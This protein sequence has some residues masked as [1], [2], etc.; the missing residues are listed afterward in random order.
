MQGGEGVKMAE[1][2][3]LPHRLWRLLP[4]GARR[5]GLRAAAG[6]LAPRCTATPPATS[7]GLIVGGEFAQATGL[8]EAAR[9]LQAAVAQLG[10]ARGVYAMA[11][12]GAADASG[13]PRDAALLL[14]V[15]APSLPLMLARAPRDLL[16]NRRVVASMAWE[17]PV[18]PQEWRVAARYVHEVWACS[19]F[20]AAALEP[21]LPGRVRV[22]P[23]PLAML[24]RP[25][26][27]VTRDDFALPEDAVVTTV[28]FGLGSSFTRKNPLAAIAAFRAAFGARPDQILVVKI[29]G[30]EAF[31]AEAGQIRAAAA[32]ADNI[33]VLSGAWAPARVEGLLG[34][35]DIVLSLHRSEG[36]GL[37]PAQAMLRGIPVV[38]TGWSGNMQ[39]MDADSAALV[40]YRLVPVS[41]PT[42]VYG[43][44][45]GAVWAAPDV[46]DAA[47]QLRRLGDDPALR[48]D[49]GAKGRAKARAALGGGELRA[50]LAANGIT[51]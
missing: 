35:T 27:P 38:A 33:R 11:V 1:K 28:I 24:D 19:A 29:T 16:R 6:V 7:R 49:L 20:T 30:Q 44:I 25:A 9:V 48:A 18:V 43:K 32:G 26:L 46:E 47:A 4:P 2:L 14:T 13:L 3:S 8:G 37:V 22:V 51:A 15:N 39:F 10:R 40:G 41:D 36:Y 31:E 5:A 21:I 42:G 23:Y 50:A 45:E 17:L 34:V 12:G